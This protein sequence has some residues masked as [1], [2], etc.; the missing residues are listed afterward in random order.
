MTAR[1][2]HDLD[3]GSATLELVVATPLLVLILLVVV[4]L[5]RLVD[6][7]MMVNDA[8]HQA[9]RAASLARTE[10]SAQAEGKQAATQAL[11][12]TGVACTRTTATVKAGNPAPGSV[13]QATVTCTASLG[14][15]SHTGLPGTMTLSAEAYSPV[16]T[17]RS[18]P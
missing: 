5:G 10:P 12:G 3:R 2:A 8:A 6:A 16:D 17:Y 7:Q 11:K 13:V 14:D 4:A 9:A 15:L 1:P 18:S